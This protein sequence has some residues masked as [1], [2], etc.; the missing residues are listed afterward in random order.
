MDCLPQE[1][2]PNQ[3]LFF[4]AS[5]SWRSEGLFGQSFSITPPIQALRGLPCLRSFS[6]VRCL[7]HIEGTPWVGSYSVDLCISHLK[8]HPGWSCSVVQ[9]VRHLMGQPLYCPAANAGMWEREA[10]VMAPPP[11]CDSAVSPCLHG[12]PAFLHRH[13]PPQSPHSHPLNLSVHSQQQPSPRYCSTIP[14][15]QLPATGPSGGC[16][17]AARTVWFSFHWGCH[18]SAVSLSALKVSLLT[19]TIAPMWESDPCFSSPTQGGQVQS[20]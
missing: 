3:S 2:W 4:R 6:V 7:R 13:F 15:L 10:M 20:Y 16:M 5:H 9:W 19:Q 12:C 17:A 18:R 1:L 14:K 11:T 8:G